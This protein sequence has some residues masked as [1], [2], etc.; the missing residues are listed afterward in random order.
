MSAFSDFGRA[1]HEAAAHVAIIRDRQR[2]VEDTLREHCS[3]VRKLGDTAIIEPSRTYDNRPFALP[4]INDKQRLLL[5]KQGI[6]V[7]HSLMVFLQGNDNREYL[8][9]I[10]DWLNDTIGQDNNSAF[11][12]SSM[13]GN[14]RI[15]VLCIDTQK[16]YY[17]LQIAGKLPTDNL[18]RNFGLEKI[19]S[20]LYPTVDLKKA[21][22]EI[23]QKE[24]N[25]GR[26]SSLPLIEHSHPYTHP[27]ERGESLTMTDASIEM[28]EGL[29]V[30]SDT[31]LL[32]HYRPANSAAWQ[33]LLNV[34][35]SHQIDHFIL[36]D[37]FDSAT[38][39]ETKV[40]FLSDS[41]V[42]RALAMQQ[43]RQNQKNQSSR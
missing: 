12:I 23:L 11:I 31:G 19:S 13:L 37:V 16:A 33:Q 18:F 8:Q 38:K 42:L 21:A 39:E 4:V 2:S 24:R 20:Q 22:V 26:L 32:L 35:Q 30:D 29:A 28:L 9:N 1:V 36:N 27:H 6:D 10:A 14:E 41:G 25:I 15:N 40:V 17:A 5:E 43:V 7:D 3:T 34:L